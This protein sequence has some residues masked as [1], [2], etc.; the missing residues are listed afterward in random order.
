MKQAKRPGLRGRVFSSLSVKL[1]G[2]AAAVF[3]GTLL[4]TSLRATSALAEDLTGAFEAKGEAIALAMAAA[5]E[6]SAEGDPLV[7]NNSVESNRK[8]RG[9]S[10]IYVQDQLGRVY[11]STFIGAFPDRLTSANVFASGEQPVGNVKMARVSFDDAG[12]TVDAIDVAA[13][14]R[15]GT[16][17][18]VHVGMDRGVIESQVNRL[19]VSMALWSGMVMLLGLATLFG[20]ILATVIRPVRELTAVTNEIVRRGDLTQTI[21]VRSSDEIGE[22][23]STFAL[24][25]EKLREIPSAISDST[26][27]LATSVPSLASATTE[28]GQMMTRQAAALQETQVTARQIQQTSAMAAQKTEAILRDTERAEAVSRTGETAVAESL[29]ALTAIR[30]QVAEI[31]QRINRLGETTLRIGEV[32]QTVKDLADQ[33][34]MLALNAAI[35]AVRSGEHGKGFSVVAGEMRRLAD[36][37]IQGTKQVRALLAEITEAIQEA[38]VIT[39]KGA[40]R[41]DAGLAQVRTSGDTLTELSRIVKENSSA[42]RQIS[43][44]VGQQNA[45]ITQIFSAVTEQ[46]RMMDETVERLKETGESVRMLTSV[47]DRLVGIVAQ[48]KV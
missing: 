17:G 19:R 37:S 12:K 20:V 45:G 18:A 8:L 4:I 46:N 31:A 39:D 7:L 27:L 22:L 29:A 32:T 44:S 38:V 40:Q 25:V 11:A 34:N 21:R 48:F 23:A 28:Q 13:P 16:L 42:V 41:I 47:S 30:S 26:Q 14:I 24:M 6:R 43:A 1:L 3:I 33:S 10:Y 15:R 5:A 9:V 2:L 36:Q 35:E